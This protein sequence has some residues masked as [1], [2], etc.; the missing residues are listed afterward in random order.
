MIVSSDEKEIREFAKELGIPYDPYFST[1]TTLSRSIPKHGTWRNKRRRQEGFTNRLALKLVRL[2]FF[3]L[4][5]G[6]ILGAMCVLA[7]YDGPLV[8][9]TAT[10]APIGTVCSLVLGAIVNKSRAEN[11]GP[12]GTGIKYA[13]AVASGFNDNIEF[14]PDDTPISTCGLCQEELKT[15][16]VKTNSDSE[17][18]SK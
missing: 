5:G 11:T 15:D 3:V 9:Y 10:F 12:N 13:A 14:V 2:L 4:L 18:E 17:S 6:F 16:D 7:G 1:A 8:C